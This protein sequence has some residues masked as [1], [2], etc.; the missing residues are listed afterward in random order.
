MVTE[1]EINF[2][3]L[4]VDTK[5]YS[6]IQVAQLI[7][8]LTKSKINFLKEDNS[9]SFYYDNSIS[10]KTLNWQPGIALEMGLK[11]YFEW[12]RK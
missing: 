5:E 7:S 12:K 6:N 4:G 3:I 10:Q 8:N 1:R 11:K 2:P 9:A